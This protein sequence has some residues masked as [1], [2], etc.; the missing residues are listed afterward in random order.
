M[1]VLG[2][3]ALTLALAACTAPPLVKSAPEPS[4]YGTPCGHPCMVRVVN[5]TS[6]PL[7]V[8]AATAEGTRVVGSVAANKEGVFGETL[9]APSYMA[10]PDAAAGTTAQVTCKPS[11]PRPGEDLL[12]QC[13]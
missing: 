12:L 11:S 2:F 7:T 10:A 1:R 3:F 13:Q 4:P 9:M 5:A 8:L 6:H